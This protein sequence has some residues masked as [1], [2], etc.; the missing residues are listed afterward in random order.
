M[1]GITVTVEDGQAVVRDGA[2]VIARVGGT[3]EQVGQIVEAIRREWALPVA[4]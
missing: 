4:V 3:A 2:T 1:E